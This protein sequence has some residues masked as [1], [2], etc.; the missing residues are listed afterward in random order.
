M[1]IR[2]SLQITG[3]AVHSAHG[4]VLEGVDVYKRQ[5]VVFITAPPLSRATLKAAVEHPKVRF[6]N[7]SVDQAYSSIRTYYGRIY[8]AKF[9]TGAIAGAMA[10][11]KMCI[12]DR[13]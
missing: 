13:S 8:E 5:Q 7:C 6:L 2:D 4:A 1:F 3:F 12:R 10:Q 9:I 11:N